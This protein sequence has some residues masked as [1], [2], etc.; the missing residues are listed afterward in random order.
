MSDVLTYTTRH[1]TS[2]ARYSITCH[3]LVSPLDLLST[4]LDLSSIMVHSYIQYTIQCLLSYS[5]PALLVLTNL[6]VLQ[7]MFLFT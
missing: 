5:L 3:V 2:L 6:S 4:C 7:F 1:V